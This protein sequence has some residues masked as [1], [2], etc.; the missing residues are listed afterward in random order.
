MGELVVDGKVVGNVNVE[1]V[2]LR[3]NAQVH[4]SITCKSLTVDPDVMICGTLNVNP[5]APE[6][7]DTDGKLIV[8]EEAA[9]A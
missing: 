4:G 8:P 2:E 5:F 9:A 3:G 6:K 7:V 1:K